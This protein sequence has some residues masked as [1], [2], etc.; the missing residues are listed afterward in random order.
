[1]LGLSE[2]LA[3]GAQALATPATSDTAGE[4]SAGMIGVVAI[5]CVFAAEEAEGA[6]ARF[7]TE[8]AQIRALF[9]AAVAEG[10]AGTLQAKLVALSGEQDSDLR[11]SSLAAAAD[12]LRDM[13]IAL[14]VHAEQSGYSELEQAIV[15][16]LHRSAHSRRLS[17]PIQPA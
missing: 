5:L 4:F 10:Q 8:N 14:H 11:L 3:G 6:A 17:I 16:F 7:C 12:R 1:M 13:L 2:V 15:A 9:A